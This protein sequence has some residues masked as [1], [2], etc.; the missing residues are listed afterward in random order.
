MIFHFANHEKSTAPLPRGRSGLRGCTGATRPGAGEGLHPRCWPVAGRALHRV[1]R[2][3]PGRP[4][5]GLRSRPSSSASPVADRALI[6]QGCHLLPS[7]LSR[8]HRAEER[9]GGVVWGF[10]VGRRRTGAP[11]VQTT[12]RPPGRLTPEAVVGEMRPPASLRFGG[13]CRWF[14]RYLD[15][16]K[17]QSQAAHTLL[18]P[19]SSQMLIFLWN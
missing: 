11:G 16:L 9:G 8:G 3:W 7:I 1:G 10:S 19:F 14:F 6:S 17:C 18:T 13:A 2:S 12:P 4:S 15:G 5:A